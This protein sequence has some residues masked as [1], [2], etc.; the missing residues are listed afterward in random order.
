MTDVCVQDERYE[1]LLISS[2]FFRFTLESV[3]SKSVNR[4][5]IFIELM[6]VHAVNIDDVAVGKYSAKRFHSNRVHTHTLHLVDR[7]LATANRRHRWRLNDGQ[8]LLPNETH[9]LGM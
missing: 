8:F 5:T 9:R 3:P 6:S 7:R 4:F 1:R 2:D